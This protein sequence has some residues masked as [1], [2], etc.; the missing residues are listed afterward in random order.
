MH[1]KS[2]FSIYRENY[3]CKR[4]IGLKKERELRGSLKITEEIMKDR[5]QERS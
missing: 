2:N 1:I 5:E 4:R 3:P